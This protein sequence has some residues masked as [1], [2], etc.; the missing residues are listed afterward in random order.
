MGSMNTSFF[1][2]FVSCRFYAIENHNCR[3]KK[4]EHHNCPGFSGELLVTL[5]C[6]HH[7]SLMTTFQLTCQ[8]RFFCVEDI[9]EKYRPC[10]VDDVDL[11]P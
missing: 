4:K 6:S 8:N 10:A 9:L 1:T 2:L 5:K 7:S 11:K 3:S